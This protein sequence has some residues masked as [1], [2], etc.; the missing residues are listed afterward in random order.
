MSQ[1]GF[2]DIANRYAGVHR[3]IFWS[4]IYSYLSTGARHGSESDTTS[5]AGSGLLD[6]NHN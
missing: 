1:L 6:C 4:V 2:F 5:G 3:Q